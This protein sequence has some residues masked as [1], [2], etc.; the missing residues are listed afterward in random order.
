[1]G[2]II[3]KQL[4]S[5]LKMKRIQN[6]TFSI[7]TNIARYVFL[8][9]VG[10]IILYPIFSMISTSLKTENAFMDV[11]SY[12]IPAEVTFDY[13]VKAADTLKYAESLKST[14]LVEVLSAALEVISCGIVAYGFARFDFKGKKIFEFILLLQILVPIQVY[15]VS[16]LTNY[17]KFDLFGILGFVNKLTGTDLRI[18]LYNT[19]FT[20]YLPSLLAVG[21]KAGVLIYIYKQFF[22]GFPKEL[23]EAASVDG[24]GPVKTFLSIV[25]PSSSV[26]I[27]T[28]SIFSLIW[29]WNDYQVASV[30]FDRNFPLAVR[31]ADIESLLSVNND[32]GSWVVKDGVKMAACLIYILPVL[33][34]YLILQNKFIKSIDRVGITG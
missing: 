26:V 32:F 24:A 23:E 19:N 6:R 33:V 18:R 1:M 29:H 22:K 28:V 12:W 30:Y 8:L 17:V 20:M 34:V 5:P 9:A 16:I 10:Y 3:V 27:L 2:G 7:I 21:I 4:T 14:I 13:F 15:I 25:V 31:L 11:T